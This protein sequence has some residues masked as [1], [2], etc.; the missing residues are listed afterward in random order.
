MHG[1]AMSQEP[2]ITD[3]S[4][5]VQCDMH[6]PPRADRPLDL[7]TSAILVPAVPR[8]AHGPGGAM[9]IGETSEER[10]LHLMNQYNTTGSWGKVI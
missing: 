6:R 4:L 3:G 7:A 2:P 9:T 10:K 1:A 5:A 8:S